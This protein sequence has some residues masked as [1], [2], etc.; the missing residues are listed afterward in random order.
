MCDGVYNMS[1]MLCKLC[2]HMLYVLCESVCLVNSIGIMLNLRDYVKNWKIGPGFVQEK[3]FVI[4]LLKI[5][6]CRNCSVQATAC[7]E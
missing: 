1:G 2:E 7:M 6:K 4:K 5:L 3:E